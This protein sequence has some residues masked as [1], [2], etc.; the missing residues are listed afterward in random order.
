MA[1]ICNKRRQH[2]L[3]PGDSSPS[4]FIIRAWNPLPGQLHCYEVNKRHLELV[5]EQIFFCVCK[6]TLQCALWDFQQKLNFLSESFALFFKHIQLW[7]HR[8][9]NYMASQSAITFFKNKMAPFTLIFY[10]WSSSL[11][12]TGISILHCVHFLWLFLWWASL[13][14]Q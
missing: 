13:V 8:V 4:W 12:P 6:I 10:G 2:Q 11:F 3:P 1:F 5:L 7:N 9:F 14:I